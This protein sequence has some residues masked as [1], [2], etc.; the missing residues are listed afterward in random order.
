MPRP[1]KDGLTLWCGS[2]DIH[3]I[4]INLRINVK[5]IFVSECVSQKAIK[6]RKTGRRNH[7]LMVPVNVR[8]KV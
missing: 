5:D 3:L 4:C 2:L 8:G 1:L 6:K 7:V